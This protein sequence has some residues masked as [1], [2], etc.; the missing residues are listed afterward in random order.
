MST[1]QARKLVPSSISIPTLPAVV[2][3]VQRMLENPDCGAREIGVVVA[4]DAPLAARVL[5][6][7]NSAYYGLRER[8]LL[9]QNAAAILGVRVLR[10]VITQAAVMRQYEHL[11][12]GEFDLDGLWKHSILVAQCASFLGKRCRRLTGL[13]P[14]E[15]HVCGLLHDLGQVVLLECMRNDYLEVVRWAKQNNAPL[16]VAEQQ[17][18]GF[19]HADVGHVVAQQWGL[20]PQVAVAILSHHGPNDDIQNNPVVALIAHTNVLVTRVLEGNLS[21]AATAFDAHALTFLG[22]TADDVT[23]AV[24]F[25]DGAKSSVQV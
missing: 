9:P 3:K 7:A 10:S 13:S 5:K 15:L 22:L 6:I 19:T 4:E 20:P 14:D 1:F 25:V 21:A 23:A 8:C 12:G 17:R 24:Q 2:Q 16:F 11:R 18:L